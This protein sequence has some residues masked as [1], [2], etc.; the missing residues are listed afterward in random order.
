MKPDDFDY[1]VHRLTR[2]TDT[3]QEAEYL[4]QGGFTA[5]VVNRLY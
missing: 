1:V 2:A 4:L 3:L 5:G